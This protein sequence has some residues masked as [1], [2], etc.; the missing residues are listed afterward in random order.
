MSTNNV[1][2]Q[3]S[4]CEYHG[5]NKYIKK[6]GKGLEKQTIKF[7]VTTETKSKLSGTWYR[8]KYVTLYNA[9]RVSKG[10]AILLRKKT[11]V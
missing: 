10:I 9:A 2:H 7:A 6:I 1:K 4:V 5:S 11:G 3:Y 8:E